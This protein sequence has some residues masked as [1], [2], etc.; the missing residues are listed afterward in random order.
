MGSSPAPHTGIMTT[1]PKAPR[2]SRKARLAR[3]IVSQII[4]VALSFL[5]LC[6]SAF[7][8]LFGDIV[9]R[10]LEPGRPIIGVLMLLAGI[11]IFIFGP[12]VIKR[13]TGREPLS[14]PPYTLH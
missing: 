9:D 11:V 12:R 7:L 4:L 3:R 14:P 6:L 1:S 2:R 8:L 10:D 5:Y 13:I